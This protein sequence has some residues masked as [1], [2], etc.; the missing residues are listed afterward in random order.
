LD[1]R[2]SGW[3]H[4]YHHQLVDFYTENAALFE[5]AYIFDKWVF[6]HAGISADWMRLAAINDPFDI[7]DLF[8][9]R[10][11]YFRFIGPDPSGDNATEGPLWIRPAS[12]I[13]N[14]VK[15]WNQCVGH[16]ENAAPY[17]VND[18]EIIVFTDTRE[19]NYL[20]MVDTETNEISHFKLEKR[21]SL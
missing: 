9:R 12:L 6:T 13:H 8:R 10:P 7:N 11:N 1:D 21:R 14:R 19:H 4:T 5:V 18:D 2:C 15:G 16:T 17:I 3:Q 20:T